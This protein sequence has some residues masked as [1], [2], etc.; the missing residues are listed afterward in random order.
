MKGLILISGMVAAILAGGRSFA[1]KAKYHNEI[2]LAMSRHV[3]WPQQIK[4]D[5]FVIGVLGCDE[6]WNSWQ[7]LAAQQAT[8]RGQKLK[9]IRFDDP[10]KVRDCQVLYISENC[11]FDEQTV[12]NSLRDA[13]VLIVSAREKG[14]RA[15]IQFI[16]KPGKLLFEID[17][18]LAHKHHL[19]FDE[20]IKKLAA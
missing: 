15:M 19:K 11:T 12:M 10:S 14:V 1:Q 13:A 6:D 17:E 9:I 20:G 18:N 16:D 2:V 8:F 4:N 5:G 3:V 7:S